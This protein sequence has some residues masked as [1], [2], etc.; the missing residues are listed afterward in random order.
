MPHSVVKKV[1]ATAQRAPTSCGIQAYSFIEIGDDDVRQKI[2]AVIGLQKAME[3]APVWIM[4]CIDFHRPYRFFN[5]L[6]LDIKFGPL[7]RL[8]TGLV[9]AS[10]AA[11]NIAIAAEAVGLGSVFIGS[12]WAGLVE[13]AGILKLPKDCMPA[14]LI[15]MGYPDRR[16]E[17]RPRWPLRSVHHE[18]AYREVKDG[19]V[20]EYYQGTN[21]A[22]TKMNYFRK[23]IANLAE[24][25]AAKFKME[26][27]GC[28]EASLTHALRKLNFL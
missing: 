12:V 2:A 15:C 8:L 3:Q 5:R 28:W 27:V 4:V 7:S 21:E 14:L 23:G 20:D 18:N 13:L 11:E 6:G 16:P 25:Y 19:E 1:L 22:L 10:L 24:H 17:L 9:D 26:E